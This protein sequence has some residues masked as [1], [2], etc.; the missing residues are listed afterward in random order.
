[1]KLKVRPED[2]RV[3]ERLNLKLKHAGAY[4]VYRLEKRLWNTL[5][6]IRHLE[7]RH[8]LR[9]VARA[10][11]KDRYSL[12]VQYLSIPGKG[13]HAIAE[14]NYSLRL[15]GMAD[16]PVS[17]DILVGNSFQ[18]RLRA[19]TADEARAIL[20]ALPQ[21]NRFGF[22][23]YYDEQRLG[24]ARHG[25][26]FI[27]RKLIDGHFNGALKLWLATPSSADDSHFR[28]TKAAL[29]RDWGDWQK[30]LELVPPEARPAIEH[31]CG[32]HKDFKG[33]IYLIPRNLLELFIN[34]YQAWL[35][36]EIMAGVLADLKTRL[37]PLE[38]SHGALAF[39]D[40]LNPAQDKYLRRLVIP[41]PG[42]GSEP[43]S[44]RVVRITSQVLAREGLSLRQLEPKLRIRGV[45]FKAYPRNAVVRPER[46]KT[47]VPDA[48]ELYPG[49]KTLL[50]S[51]FLPAGS[52]ATILV[53]RLSL[54]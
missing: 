17:R 27:A 19:L 41:A 4:S 40:E 16:Q 20:S 6:V 49:R 31:L 28:Q 48:D 30:C 54:L 15:A 9:H 46:M 25:Q 34:A 5:D 43:T 18:V 51:F 1:M 29:E 42:P 2:F 11:L 13:P 38:Y 44:E 53:K 23:N 35:W 12:S 26:G 3:E 8:G 10:G 47:S 36:N 39:Y 22:P 24:S 7:Q 14:K 32:S 45:F 37:R 33:A 21:V 52:F 50:L